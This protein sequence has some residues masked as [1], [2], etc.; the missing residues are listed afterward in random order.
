MKKM[1]QKLVA[2]IALA[3]LV[4][5]GVGATVVVAQNDSDD[6]SIAGTVKL[7]L[8]S[9]LGDLTDL[10]SITRNEAIAA[11]QGELSATTDPSDVELEVENGFLVWEIEV[12]GQEVVVDAGSGE[13]LLIES[14]EADDDDDETEDEAVEGE[15]DNN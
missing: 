3:A 14:E 10:A 13:V 4:L 9:R 12:A 8:G 6:A 1:N 11:A 5:A 15:D 7:P 2:V